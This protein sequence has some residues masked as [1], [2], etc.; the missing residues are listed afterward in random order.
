TTKTYLIT[1]AAGFIGSY[2]SKKLLDECCRVVGIDYLNDYYDV[3]LKRARL[4]QLEPYE[5]FT[6]IEGDIA[7]KAGLLDIFEECRPDIVV[8]LAAQAGVRYSI[9][10]PDVYIQSNL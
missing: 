7:N 6:F 9:E 2:L 5:A 1:G 10:N 4:E 3:D 8:N